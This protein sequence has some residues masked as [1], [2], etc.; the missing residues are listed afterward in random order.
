[1]KFLEKVFKNIAMAVS[2]P[3]L[4]SIELGIYSNEDSFVAM[5]LDQIEIAKKAQ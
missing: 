3:G 2:V 1:M 5:S 4:E